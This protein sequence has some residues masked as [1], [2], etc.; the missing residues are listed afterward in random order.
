MD[1][2]VTVDPIFDAFSVPATVTR[3]NEAPIE[4]TAVWVPGGRWA[5]VDRTGVEFL[6]ATRRRV[7]AFRVDEVP[8]TPAGTLILAPEALGEEPQYW[9]VDEFDHLENDLTRVFV[10]PMK[11]AEYL[12]AWG[13]RDT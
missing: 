1:I 7:I 3:P 2:R 9:R 4:T 12:A 8:A 13:K 11:E 5:D 10:M 6:R